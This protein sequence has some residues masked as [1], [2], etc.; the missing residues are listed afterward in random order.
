[1]VKSVT[2]ASICLVSFLSIA[3][4]KITDGDLENYT[5]GDDVSLLSDW[6]V[7]GGGS[8][9]QIAADP[10]SSGRGNVIHFV[11]T[12]GSAGSKYLSRTVSGV[13]ANETYTISAN[14][15]HIDNTTFTKIIYTDTA[16]ASQ[17]ITNSTIAVT[18]NAWSPVSENWTAPADLDE[19]QAVLFQIYFKYGGDPANIY[20]DDFSVND[21]K[22]IG[23]IID[24]ADNDMYF[25]ASDVDGKYLHIMRLPYADFLQNAADLNSGGGIARGQIT[26]WLAANPA[27]RY[28]TLAELT[29]YQAY[30]AAVA[31]NTAR[32]SL[33]LQHNTQYSPWTGGSAW[34][35]ATEAIAQDGGHSK[36]GYYFEFKKSFATVS[37]VTYAGYLEYKNKK[38][39]PL[40]VKEV[41]DT[42]GDGIDDSIDSDDDNDGYSD[43]DEQAAGSDSL[44]DTSMP[45]DNDGDFISDVTDTDDD[46]DGTLDT[47]D[48]FVF[49]DAADTDTDSDGLPDT[50][51]V[52]CDQACIDSS[53]LTLDDDDD[54]DGVVDANDLYPLDDSQ[55]RDAFVMGTVTDEPDN[56]ISWQSTDLAGSHVQIMRLAYADHLD[57]TSVAYGA[58]KGQINTWLAANP[59]W[60]WATE[61][62]LYAYRDYFL[63]V[64]GD[65][66]QIRFI[67]HNIEYSPQDTNLWIIATET[68][69]QV[70]GDTKPAYRFQFNLNNVVSDI[71]YSGY[72]EFKGGK[73]AALLVADLTDADND[74]DGI[75]DDIDPDDDNDG[76]DDD[77]DAFPFNDAA[78]LDTDTD[79]QPDDFLPSCDQSCIDNSGL[80]LDTDDDNDGVLDINDDFILNAAAA[81]DTDTDGF[82]DDFLGDCN[83]ACID[84]SGLTLDEDDD[85]DGVLD[86]NDDFTVNASASLDTDSDGLPDYF[87]VGCDQTCIDASGLIL[88]ND[89]DNDGVNDQDD[90]Y[91]L[92]DSK[93]RD[94]YV[95]GTVT[96][97]SANTMY[98]ETDS[99]AGNPV[100]ILRLPYADFLQNAADLNSGGG[101]ARGQITTWLAA[102]PDWRFASF[103]EIS[104]YSD[105]FVAVADNTARENLFLQ[106]N[107][108]Y[109]PWTGGSAWWIAT[110]AIE[111]D[112]ADSKPGYYVEFKKSFATVSNVTY[113]G[114]L[115]YKNP[116]IAPLIVRDVIDSDGDG[117]FDADDL[118]DDNDG[119]EDSFDAFPTDP[120]A[121]VDID[122][123]GLPDAYN[124]N[125]DQACIDSSDLELD[126][127][128]IA[129]SDLSNDIYWEHK[130]IDGKHLH[131]MRLPYADHLDKTDVAY[132]AT[133]LEVRAWLVNNSDWR[134]AT[135]AEM[136][137]YREFLLEVT[138]TERQ[139]RFL[140]LNTEYS[141][142][143]IEDKA[144]DPAVIQKWMIVT[145]VEAQ[146][147]GQPNPVERF[148]FMENNTSAAIAYSGNTN[149]AGGVVVPLL[150][151]EVKDSDNDGIAD[152]LDQYPYDHFNSAGKRNISEYLGAT[153][154]NAMYN[155]TNKPI[156]EEGSDFLKMMGSSAI[157]IWFGS[158]YRVNYVQNHDWDAEGTISS[159][160]ELAQ[161]SYFST[162]FSDPNFTTYSMELATFDNHTSWKDGLTTAERD[163][164]YNEVYEFTAH[165]LTTYHNT[166]KIFI[167]QNWE[168]DNNLGQNAP[169]EKVQG[170]IDWLNAR[171][172]AITDARNATNSTNVYVF[173][174][175]EANKIGQQDWQG[176]R[177]LTDVYP[178]L[179]MDLYSYSNWYTK[180]D[181]AVLL[182]DINRM[183]Q[184]APDSD[185]FGSE[186]IMV[187]EFGQ[188]RIVGGG[189]NA[190]GISRDEEYSYQVTKIEQEIGFDVG[191]RFAFFWS[192]YDHQRDKS[193]GLV[194]DQVIQE[195]MVPEAGLEGTGVDASGRYLSKNYDYFKDVALKLDMMEDLAYD[196]SLITSQSNMQMAEQV[197]MDKWDGD[198]FRFE[199]TGNV[200]E[201]VYGFENDL[202]RAAFQLYETLDSG[203]SYSIAVSTT[204][205]LGSF[206]EVT[207]NVIKG[208][209]I[210]DTTVA[211]T[212]LGWQR[213]LI[214]NLDE[215]PADSR[216]IKL[217]IINGDA[218]NVQ[219]SAG[220]FYSIKD[221]Q[222]QA[223]QFGG[224][225]TELINNNYQNQINGHEIVQ[226][227][228]IDSWGNGVDS[229]VGTETGLA[230]TGTDLAYGL[231][232]DKHF[233][234]IDYPD[235]ITRS[236]IYGSL[237][238]GSNL[239][240]LSSEIPV[241]VTT[242]GGALTLVGNSIGINDG[243][244]DASEASINFNFQIEIYLKHIVLTDYDGDEVALSING[245]L[246]SADNYATAVASWDVN[247]TVLSIDSPIVLQTSDTL[248]VAA[249]N[250]EFGLYSVVALHNLI[251]DQDNDG[252][253]DSLDAFPNN[254]AAS[255][256]T[257]NDGLPDE[258]HVAC[259]QGCDQDCI[260]NSG[261]VLDIDDDNDGVTDLEDAFSLNVAASTDTD[262]DGQPDTFLA[263]CDQACIANSGLTLDN[264]DDN[265][266]VV[267]GEDTF[268]LDDSKWRLTYAIGELSNDTSNDMYWETTS[269]AGTPMQVMRL[270]YA[271]HLDQV[272]VEY[273]AS[274]G[275]INDWFKVNDGWRFA[276]EVELLAYYDF[277]TELTGDERQVRFLTFN[278]EFSPQYNDLWQVVTVADAENEGDNKPVYRFQFNDNNVV[279]DIEYV[280]YGEFKV[281]KAA[282]LIVRSLTDFDADGEYDFADSDD[283]NDGVEDSLDAFPLNAA[284]SIDI[285]EDGLA[286]EF[287]VNCDQTCQDNSGLTLDDEVLK[288]IASISGPDYV[289][290]DVTFI[291]DGTGS[292][293]TLGALTYEWRQITDAGV[294]VL[295]Y[296]DTVSI[297]A[298]SSTAETQELVFELAVT[299]G[300]V[301]ETIQK[302]VKVA[303]ITADVEG[304][305]SD[306]SN[307]IYW[308]MSD[309]AGAAK[310][311][312]RLDYADHLD[313]TDVEYGAS[314]VEIKAWLADNPFWRWATQAELQ[315]YAD[316]FK[317]FTG[318]ERQAQFLAMNNE[319]SPENIKNWSVIVSTEAK[320]E[321]H[322]NPVYKLII[323]SN[324]EVSAVTY[325]GSLNAKSGLIAPLLLRDI[326][327]TD[328][329]GIY[330]FDDIYPYDFD[331][332][333]Y[334]DELENEL[335]TDPKDANDFP[336]DTDGD[337]I[338][339]IID[340][341][342]D[343]DGV[344]DEL[345]S[346]PLN[347][348]ASVDID[349]DGLPEQFNDSCE[350]A[351]IDSSGLV[352]D[353]DFV[354]DLSLQ[355]PE[356]VS[357]EATTHKTV[358][359]THM[360]GLPVSTGA[361]KI[362][363]ELMDEYELGEYEVLW[364]ATGID[365]AEV[366]S[367]QLINILD[368][369]AP[370]LPWLDD[371]YLDAKG[372]FT[373]INEALFSAVI[374]EDAVEGDIKA[375]ILAE[376]AVMSGVH[377]ITWTAEDS[378]GNIA[379]V[380]QTLFIQPLLSLG[381]D[382][383]IETS[384]TMPLRLKLTG[385]AIN[386][387]VVADLA[388]EITQDD[389]SL[390]YDEVNVQLFEDEMLTHMVDYILPTGIDASNVAQVKF[391]LLN[392]D[393]AGLGD[394]SNLLTI[395]DENYAPVVSLRALVDGVNSTIVDKSISSMLTLSASV[396]DINTLD[397]HQYSWNSND[398]TLMSLFDDA[399]ALE[400]DT[401]SLAPGTYTVKFTAIEVEA[402][403][404]GTAQLTFNVYDSLAVLDEQL[405]SDG[406][407]ITD[408]VEGYNDSDEDGIPD[409]LDNVSDTSILPLAKDDGLYL[410]THA[411]LT[412]KLGSF[413]IQKDPAFAQGAAIEVVDITDVANSNYQ[414]QNMRY[415]AVSNIFDFEI[416]GLATAG[417]SADIVIP[418][419]DLAQIS[420]TAVY[421]KF[422]PG[423]G[424]QDFHIDDKNVIA[425]AFAE[426]GNCP[427]IYSQAYVA[428][429][430]EGTHC[431]R[432]T[433]EDG[434]PN[435]QDGIANG[436]I[437]DPGMITN[438]MA[439]L[440]PVIFIDNIIN[441]G[442]EGDSI[443]LDAANSMDHDDNPLSYHWQLLQGEEVL[444]TIGTADIVDFILPEVMKDEEY[445]VKV[446]VSDGELESTSSFDLS[447]LNVASVVT[448]DIE[449]IASNVQG[450]LYVGDKVV[451]S[452]RNSQTNKGELSYQWQQLTA[453][454]VELIDSGS[455]EAY[456]IVPNLEQDTELT[457]ELIVDNGIG[458]TSSSMSKT[459]SL[460]IKA[461]G[462]ARGEKTA[463]SHGGAMSIY[464]LLLIIFIL[465]FR[466]TS[467]LT[468][469]KCKS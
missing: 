454:G 159:I 52:G 83:Q 184:Y 51:L 69:V 442:F 104:A 283:D 105:Y 401:N 394:S 210:F 305:V 331:N 340:S 115:E 91:P 284:A 270:P 180:L 152:H 259:E 177:M 308:E 443:Q 390:V 86:I 368:V 427:E 413:A 346:F 124:T 130:N 457:I 407:G 367:I 462:A 389:G 452:G 258:F 219:Y 445:M 196:F 348:A 459:V 326:I 261:L 426:N 353:D 381:L 55:W 215:L 72:T 391:E 409:Y 73:V 213:V 244:L 121:S 250:G 211:Q 380:E 4:E 216:F 262:G 414:E 344:W 440:P 102:N 143:S 114:Y 178:H 376:G 132:G 292:S 214:K 358:I 13:K 307:L 419:P 354:S 82:P 294:V 412:L 395:S 125:C 107:I 149:T 424:W 204:G 400:I 436:T 297:T 422:I 33:F 1:M 313:K 135:L 58:S 68:E 322:A 207:T 310:H 382:R 193:L 227:D 202:N 66:R 302:T 142:E 386:Y 263:G 312:M 176:K 339:D 318:D 166:G 267:D 222:S 146:E 328:L 167:L 370:V 393:N 39:A 441:E 323:K 325:A 199:P 131:L 40:L 238:T 224:D 95:M 192:S 469:R 89:D 296:Q 335:G 257:D 191:T 274:K 317:T 372:T 45:A 77:Q 320:E 94:A 447:V 232:T 277:F 99:L 198:K 450:V 161:T 415:L 378:S 273:G 239:Q 361:V 155:F 373:R 108:E 171:Q 255:V 451:L 278:T 295:D 220:R 266:G 76:V 188:K 26:T 256:D 448:S 375:S 439:N 34:W 63:A 385:K 137:A 432:V 286:D 139:T 103:D 29:A 209:E 364:V 366:S 298:P 466:Q 109:S 165:L 377:T 151:R 223:I 334:N 291:L 185:I 330:D 203:V 293:A 49:N 113:A 269:L 116:K 37:N 290:G 233:N 333:G 141:P 92:D 85:N 119:V 129:I 362:T 186:N 64:S 32:E 59:Q 200:A 84:S 417:S 138:G 237:A 182:D 17:T 246:I 406:D 251:K 438:W 430:V 11:R 392:V 282:P 35:I 5:I 122:F 226:W 110:E 153:H 403:L 423:Q 74:G 136:T 168:G 275:Q 379:K 461:E 337:S 234:L 18:A 60:R 249:V 245:E 217:T 253:K 25:D 242:V 156:L 352:L 434:G 148:P 281:G 387:P 357:F 467:M 28:A 456:F 449:V 140:T 431:V 16:G 20:Y 288:V 463:K 79:G 201:I 229:A 145:E 408:A 183:K 190:D 397:Q 93:W 21:G 38:N 47:D 332:D 158:D 421:R 319:Y 106:H 444:T 36:P 27:W 88:D 468:R 42:D 338:P 264:D 6:G 46:N 285:D 133:T 189:N 236:A 254:A 265:D 134:R 120:A 19:N 56:N 30:F 157:K 14:V 62:E 458:D 80:I 126:Q 61:Q 53:G 81:L 324:N 365:G 410:T 70:D 174:A 123:D 205:E 279:S 75:V 197:A 118:D 435:D 10:D 446:T 100:H 90:L 405:D 464:Y 399:K 247:L 71:T 240:A 327:D 117:I 12:T 150:V 48:A 241:S 398:E 252:V 356:S 154:M 336:L 350:Q 371:V 301:T 181:E 230:A 179:H 433:I 351:C 162:L 420:A 388:V 289:A 31:D 57:Q 347:P 41:V 195:Y 437:V 309:L 96:D 187:G 321:G 465:L 15:R 206:V 416:S 345:D 147:E 23:D 460:T 172:D 314:N 50:F 396:R 97:D 342:D 65:D 311:I 67:S 8:T 316:Y 44:D 112:G 260:D 243:Y 170:M 306:A 225:V 175:A 374:S 360:L 9:A 24:D 173:G 343:N 7:H 276:T 303:A 315:A 87:L 2:L 429:L 228:G 359:E 363:A 383:I 341:D 453:V 329:D 127:S 418:M 369:H 411:G 218:A 111:Q 78:V 349:M 98:W 272:D 164:I 384:A 128:V 271:D 43:I 160:T 404:S 194:L 208:A 3:G 144:T 455:E 221:K 268:P 101:V 299:Y 300:D 425:S 402:G 428:G 235:G 355:A 287:H 231:Y 304:T 212:P 248:A 54:N 169:D 280:G 163:V 22:V